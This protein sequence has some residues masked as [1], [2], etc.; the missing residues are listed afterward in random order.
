MEVYHVMNVVYRLTFPLRATPSTPQVFFIFE[1]ERVQS[2]HTNFFYSYRRCLHL[3]KGPT[4]WEN[5][6]EALAIK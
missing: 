2:T 5:T 4:Y 1:R 3:H 6:K